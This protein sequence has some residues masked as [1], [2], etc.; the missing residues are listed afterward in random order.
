LPCAA[1]DYTTGFVMAAGI[2]EAIDESLDD[3]VARRVDGSLCQTAAW[4]CAPVVSTSM[5]QCRRS[6]RPCSVQ[7]PTSVWSITS[8]RAWQSMVSTSDGRDPPRHLG[9]GRSRGEP[10]RSVGAGYAGR[11]ACSL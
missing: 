10:S 4:S 2:M 1:T 7:I 8:G 11:D 5:R 3:G 9:T 6:L